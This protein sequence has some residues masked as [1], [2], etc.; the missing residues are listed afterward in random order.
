MK[1]RVAMK[2]PVLDVYA[3]YA[4]NETIRLASSSGGIFT[5]IAEHILGQKGV[6]YGVTLTEV[7]Y[8]AVFTRVTTVNELHKLQGSKYLQ[9]KVGS[10][11]LNV[12]KDLK[13]GL[14]VLFSGTG[15]QVNGLK[16]FLGKEYDN[17]FCLDVIC[18]GTPSPA[19]WKKYVEY[20]EKHGEKLIDVNFRD[21]TYGWNNYGMREIDAKCKSIYR[22]K[23]QNPYM[24]MFLRDYCL[25]PSCYACVAKNI[26]C[27]DITIA[28]FWGINYVAPKMNDE[29]GTS[30]VILRTKK[31]KTVFTQIQ[32]DITYKAVSYEDGVRQNPAEYR[33]SPCPSQRK[34]FYDDMNNLT[35]EELIHK[36]AQ[37]TTTTLK[38]KIRSMIKKIIFRTIGPIKKS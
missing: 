37:P 15:C 3:A 31:G 6:V 33:S 13:D 28:D 29:K 12:Q 8:S 20:R 26:K 5:V 35:F 4:K 18:H 24:L 16:A 34:Y 36:Y 32:N 23:E 38:R 10:I 27:S 14:I 19:L 22:S 7:C 30:L 1:G 11:Y 17:L 21:K 2:N 9:A 25:R